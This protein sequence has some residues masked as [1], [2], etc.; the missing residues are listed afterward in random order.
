MRSSMKP[1]TL[2]FTIY[3]G[4]TFN[5][6]LAWK[7]RTDATNTFPKDISIYKIRMQIRKKIK[8]EDVL[9]ELSTDNGRIQKSDPV[10]GKFNL[11]LSSVETAAL[12]FNQAI[13]DLE[14]YIE[15]NPPA[16]DI[17]LRLL[18]GMVTLDKEVTRNVQ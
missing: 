10:N 9:L 17:V 4:S 15:Q 18:S 11:V 5:L 16:A 2:N 3:Q 1:G 6:T 14:F 8:D 13:Y 12:E 7:V